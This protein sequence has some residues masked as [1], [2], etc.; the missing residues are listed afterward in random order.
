MAILEKTPQLLLQTHKPPIFT[1]EGALHILCANRREEEAIQLL[2]IAR[3]HLDATQAKAFLSTQ[4]TGAFF[5]SPPMLW[6]GES[7]LSYACVFGLRELVRRMVETQVV[8][9]NEGAGA[10]R[11]LPDPRRRPTATAHV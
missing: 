10:H 6:Y 2:D 4:A 1:G 9:L 11:L 3:R 8:S 7:P 5:E